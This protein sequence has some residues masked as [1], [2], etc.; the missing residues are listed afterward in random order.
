MENAALAFTKR[1]IVTVAPGA[2][3]CLSTGPLYVW[4]TMSPK[5]FGT[6]SPSRSRASKTS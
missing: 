6:R 2:S 1:R 3:A 4:W 5:G